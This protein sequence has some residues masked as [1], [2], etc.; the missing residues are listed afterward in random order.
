MDCIREINLNNSKRKKKHSNELSIEGLFKILNFAAFQPVEEIYLGFKY[1]YIPLHICL[2]IGIIGQV[3]ILFGFDIYLLKSLAIYT[4]VDSFLLKRAYYLFW[5]LSGFWGWGLYQVMQKV[6]FQKH[7]NKVFLNCGLK[8]AFGKTPGFIFDRS[9]DID[10]RKLALR[11]NGLSFKQFEQ[12]LDH[13]ANNLQIYTDSISENREKG[14]IEV[15]YARKDLVTDFKM[16][17]I[18]TLKKNTL[19]LGQGRSKWIQ[20][21]ITATPHLLIAGQTGYGKSTLLRSLITTMYLNNKNCVFDLI[22]L[23]FGLEMQVFRGLKRVSIHESV[24][25]GVIALENACDMIKTRAQII[26][27]NNCADI[28]Q[29]LKIPEDRRIYPPNQIIPK[30]FDRYIIAIDEAFDLFMVGDKSTSAQVQRVRK[31]ASTIAAKGR[32]LGIHLWVSTQRPDRFALDPQT[33]A[34]LTGV[35]AFRVPNLATSRTILD[36]GRAA[37][38]PDQVGRAIW[39]TSNMT[40]QFQA[41]FISKDEVE[42][43][44]LNQK[45]E[46]KYKELHSLDKTNRSRSILQKK[47]TGNKSQSPKS[48]RKRGM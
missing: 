43:I 39:Q 34:N 46:P 22:D 32:A 30:N 17:E 23:K 27:F 11:K 3:I 10:T 44:F 15:L 4:P 28:N 25:E 21:D 18:H 16:P 14:S 1:K 41:P 12:S 13:L 9:V 2:G 26:K 36:N 38:L 24:N 47:V 42:E 33:K 31:A 5:S 6:R 48:E 20:T 35:I 45:D 7:L 19:L 29:F 8:N 37:E 40:V